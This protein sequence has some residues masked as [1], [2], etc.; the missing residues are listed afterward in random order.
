MYLILVP[1]SQHY[2]VAI[3]LLVNMEELDFKFRIRVYSTLTLVGRSGIDLKDI[4]L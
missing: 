2:L 4:C 3:K 1:V